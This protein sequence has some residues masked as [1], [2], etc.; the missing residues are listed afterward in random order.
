[1]LPEQGPHGRADG[2]LRRR[3]PGTLRVGR[4]R[5]QQ[6]D[7]VVAACELA[8]Q[9]EVG[10]TPVDRREIQLEVAGVDDRALGGEERDRESVRYGV[11][12]RHELAVARSYTAPLAVG[13]RD[14][15]R[16]AG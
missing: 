5:E 4:I 15:L 11:G 6:P 7:A 9:R 8:Q 14:D 2:R 13:P 1:M 10:V 12:D 3:E 16:P